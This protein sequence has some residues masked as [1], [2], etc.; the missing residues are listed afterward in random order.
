LLLSI[1]GIEMIS[2]RQKQ[3]QQRLSVVWSGIQQTVVNKATDEWRRHLW[4]CV[5][6]F[7][8]HFEYL[9]Q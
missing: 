7:G 3:L 5:C 2:S 9:L 8:W 1:A 6:V 4:A